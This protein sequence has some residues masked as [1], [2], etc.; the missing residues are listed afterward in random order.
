MFL[1]RETQDSSIT[2]L[3]YYHE[4]INDILDIE[5]FL[6]NLNKTV[7]IINLTLY[8]DDVAPI[9]WKLSNMNIKQITNKLNF[10]LFVKFKDNNDLNVSSMTISPCENLYNYINYKLKRKGTQVFVTD[11]QIRRTDKKD[12]YF[13]I[14]FVLHNNYEYE[15]HEWA[16]KEC[17]LTEG[18]KIYADM[19]V[20]NKYDYY[21]EDEL[22]EWIVKAILTDNMDVLK[23]IAYIY[24]GSG[25]SQDYTPG[26]EPYSRNIIPHEPYVK[27]ALLKIIHDNYMIKVLEGNNDYWIKL[28]DL[29]YY[30]SCLKNSKNKLFEKIYTSDNIELIQYIYNLYAEEEKDADYHIS[31]IKS[32]ILRNV[33]PKLEKWKQRLDEVSK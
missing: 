13:T 26:Y 19:K 22:K 2:K 3:R 29:C 21:T 6:L 12:C 15:L 14:N 9:Y 10:N 1:E 28:I 32:S 7:P 24:D 5:K 31:S 33:G 23:T 18:E 30:N 27:A 17:I 4:G 16:K 25:K 8:R 20:F 11:E